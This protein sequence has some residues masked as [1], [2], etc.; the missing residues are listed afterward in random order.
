MRCRIH[1]NQSFNA[2]AYSGFLQQFALDGVLDSFAIVN[3]STR[4][5]VLA[6]KGRVFSLDEQQ[7]PLIIEDD[8]ID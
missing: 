4:E 2:C 6:L 7:S 3:K 1:A 5:S 8:G